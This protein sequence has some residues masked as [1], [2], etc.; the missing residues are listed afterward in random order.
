MCKGWFTLILSEGN[1]PMCMLGYD[2]EMNRT[3]I[4]DS[5]MKSANQ[6]FILTIEFWDYILPAHLYKVVRDRVEPIPQI[7]DST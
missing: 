6:W 2:I 5:L 3:V 1:D 7:K 4:V